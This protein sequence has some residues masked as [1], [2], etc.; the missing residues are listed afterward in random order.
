MDMNETSDLKPRIIQFGSE[1][2]VY[3]KNISP[4]EDEKS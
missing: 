4:F 3:P 2:W 1:N